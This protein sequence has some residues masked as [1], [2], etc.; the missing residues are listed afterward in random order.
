MSAT[1]NGLIV[2]PKMSRVMFGPKG[3]TAN[4]IMETTMVNIG[5]RANMALFAPAGVMSSLKNNLIPSATGWRI[6]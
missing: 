1:T 3:T 6:P 5:A 2:I 4:P